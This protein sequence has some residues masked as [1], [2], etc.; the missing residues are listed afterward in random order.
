MHNQYI[1]IPMRYMLL[2]I[3]FLSPRETYH[4]ILFSTQMDVEIKKL[5]Y[6]VELFPTSLD[7]SSECSLFPGCSPK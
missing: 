4:A 2:Y 5:E 6:S 1:L 7:G 3:K